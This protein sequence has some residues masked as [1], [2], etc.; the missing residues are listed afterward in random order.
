VDITG[1]YFSLTTNKRMII[2]VAVS[3][4]R[5]SGSRVEG[6][7]AIVED[8]TERENAKL[9]Q[10]S[11]YEIA[12]LASR[13][14]DQNE[15][16]SEIHR[17][18]NGLIPAENF[19][20]AL[21]DRSENIVT[22]P[23]F[24][25]KNDPN[26]GPRKFSNGMTEYVLKTGETFFA[27]PENYDRLNKEHGVRDIGTASV[28]WLGVPLKNADG[29]VLGVVVVQ[30]YDEEIRYSDTEKS[31]LEY[32]STQIAGAIERFRSRENEVQH[33]K[34]M[35]ALL[36]TTSLINSSLEIT[37]VFDE[38]LK[39]LNRF[40]TYD[41][42]QI[43]LISGNAAGIHTE[44]GKKVEGQEK[45]LS[46]PWTEIPGFRFIAET[47]EPLILPD[48]REYKDWVKTDLGEW[49]RSYAGFPLMVK[50]KVIGFLNLNS[51]NSGYFTR[52]K[53]QHLIAFADQAAVAIENARLYA[54]VQQLAIVDELTG[55]YNRR[56]FIEI[57]S[58]DTDRA[59]RHNLPMS[60]LFLDIDNFKNFN[61]TYG[62]QVGDE[63]LKIFAK[64]IKSHLRAS[65]VCGRYG[66]DEFVILL[67]EARKKEALKI[68]ERVKAS[69]QAEEVIAENEQVRITTSI[70]L[71]TC[72]AKCPSLEVM[73]DKA[74]KLLQKSKK[75]G[76]NLIFQN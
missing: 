61:D 34:F 18:I 62:Y 52:D 74:G 41:S 46:V 24:V 37:Q 72:S 55:I 5:V 42:A 12:S 1:E 44:Y 60:L 65:D 35:E 39:N 38:I 63:V 14:T 53:V 29:Q 73:I 13:V 23:Y 66:G 15:L 27:R 71:F 17:I 58:H 6:G 45:I 31:I 33:Q 47:G 22:F 2:H 51:A 26:P 43:M 76:K 50:N 19:F 69:V 36:D 67:T 3:P 16:F 75:I 21:W 10:S 25:D 40:I 57:A 4:I 64:T 20:I 48:V 30:S 54:E 68:A 8:I 11:I 7:I 59:R 56:G 49:I 32:V 9:I 70:G 28:D